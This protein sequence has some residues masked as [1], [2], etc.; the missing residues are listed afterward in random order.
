[1]H[2]IEVVYV[3]YLPARDPLCKCYGTWHGGSCWVRSL[4]ALSAVGLHRLTGFGVSRHPIWVPSIDKAN[5]AYYMYIAVPATAGTHYNSNPSQLANRLRS[6]HNFG[7]HMLCLSRFASVR[8]AGKLKPLVARRVSSSRDVGRPEPA[9]T[10]VQ[11]MDKHPFDPHSGDL[12]NIFIQS[13]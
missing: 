1:M 6:R 7:R 9:L 5:R 11:F 2:S 12:T 13:G 4:I 10:C 3:G 8:I